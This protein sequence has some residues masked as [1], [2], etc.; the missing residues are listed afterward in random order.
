MNT[1]QCAADAAVQQLVIGSSDPAVQAL[2]LESP[3]VTT[4]L[5]YYG[6]IVD[7]LYNIDGGGSIIIGCAWPVV[8]FGLG[9]SIWRLMTKPSL[10]AGM[11]LV[12]MALT[13]CD[14]SVISWARS[15]D[16]RNI[17]QVHLW[18]Y[19]K[20]LISFSVARSAL[21]VIASL[22]RYR[23]VFVKQLHQQ[24]LVGGGSVIAIGAMVGAYVTGYMGLYAKNGEGVTNAFWG[25]GIIQPI[26][27]SVLGLATFTLKLRKNRVPGVSSSTSEGGRRMRDLEVVNNIL[28]FTTIGFCVVVCA[29]VFGGDKNSYYP[30]VVQI[31]ASAYWS[32]GENTFELL[33]SFKNTADKS[34][35]NMRS[36]SRSGNGPSQAQLQ[37]VRGISRKQLDSPDHHQPVESAEMA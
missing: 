4:T 37:Y 12:V 17:Y 18:R 6:E 24:I 13:I 25:I 21:L 9:V 33:A 22:L 3:V 26:L 19:G 28:M 14:L 36:T 23:A 8:A 34:V 2:I 1:A 10:R 15:S 30:T 16:L 29:V 20:L 35:A 27:Y 7:S 5:A 31:S 32:V 11:L